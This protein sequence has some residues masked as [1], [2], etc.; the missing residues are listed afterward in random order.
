MG[1]VAQ[2][3]SLHLQSSWAKAA[4]MRLSSPT[5]LTGNA[6]LMRLPPF[7][8]LHLHHPWEDPLGTVGVLL[9]P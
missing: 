2:K 4:G 3:Q 7:T 9:Q 1:L 6:L 8:E 5:A